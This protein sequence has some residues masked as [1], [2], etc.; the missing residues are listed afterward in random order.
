LGKYQIQAKQHWEP[1]TISQTEYGLSHL[2]AHEVTYEGEK[3]TFEFVVTYGL[4][5]FTKDDDAHSIP[6]V[7]SDGKETRQINLERYE[8]S[9][10]LRH[11]VESFDKNKQKFY[12]TDK[13]KFFTVQQLCSFSNTIEPYKICFC[14]FKENRLLRLHITTAFFDRTGRPYNQ[15]QYSIF[16]IAMDAQRR[17]KNLLLPIEARKN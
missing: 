16:K 12:E 3:A 10:K 15:K 14:A 4:H 13:E 6:S 11:L 17:D 1:F 8:T 2:T 5:C 7:Y 9:K